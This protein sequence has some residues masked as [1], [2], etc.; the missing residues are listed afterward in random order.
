MTITLGAY[1]VGTLLR[2][3][4]ST[5]TSSANV[6]SHEIKPNAVLSFSVDFIHA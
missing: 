6:A 4:R 2:H 3:A 1:R 5:V